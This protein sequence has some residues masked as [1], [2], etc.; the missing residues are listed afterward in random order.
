[1]SVLYNLFYGPICTTGYHHSRK[2]IFI[3]FFSV[4]SANLS[5]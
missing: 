4:I 3:A 2:R 1:M 5:L